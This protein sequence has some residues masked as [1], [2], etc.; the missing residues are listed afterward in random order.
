MV[1]ANIGG[2]PLTDALKLALTSL[3]AMIVMFA[4]GAVWGWSIHASR[5]RLLVA[6]WQWLAESGSR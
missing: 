4:G 2:M 6:G 3:S 1:L 5:K